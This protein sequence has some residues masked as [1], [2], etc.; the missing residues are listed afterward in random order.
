MAEYI[1]IVCPNCNG[2]NRLPLKSRY[3]KAKCGKCGN[4]LLDTKPVDLNPESFHIHIAKNDIPVLVDFW[5]PWCGPCQ[6]MAPAF[7][8]A[9]RAFALKVRF[10][11]LNTED[12][13][14]ISAQFGIR[15]IPTM[16]LFHKGREIDRVSGAL[17][18][19]QIVH[20]V[21]SHLG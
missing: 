19:Q 9:A 18:S 11:K 15:G 13:P 10:G 12:Y 5:A 14:E 4:D 21:N 8:E 7:E 17:N 1:H 2:V 3:S 16:I 6:M 20:W